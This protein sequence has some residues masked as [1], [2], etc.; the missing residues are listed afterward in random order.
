MTKLIPMVI[1]GVGL[2]QGLKNA[3]PLLDYTRIFAVQTEINSISQIIH[4]ESLDGQ[5]LD[6]SQFEGFLK[7]HMSVQGKDATRDVSKDIWGS[8]YKLEVRDNFA[9]VISAGPDKKFGTNDD[10]RGSTRL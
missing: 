9:T 5:R 8:S 1:M 3:E 7:K 10:V 2:Q 6:P 4:L